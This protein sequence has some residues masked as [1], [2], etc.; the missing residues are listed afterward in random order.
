MGLRRADCQVAEALATCSCIAL[1]WRV[2]SLQQNGQFV[3]PSTDASR[4]FFVLAAEEGACGPLT[5]TRGQVAAH[6]RCQTALDGVQGER[7]EAK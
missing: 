2:A 1:S 3:Q 6:R 5:C 4:A 7:I